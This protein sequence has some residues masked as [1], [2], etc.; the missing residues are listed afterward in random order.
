MEILSKP[1][2]GKSQQISITEL[3]HTTPECRFCFFFNEVFLFFKS[4]IVFL[5]GSLDRLGMTGRGLGMTGKRAREDRRGLG[6]TG[7]AGE[8]ESDLDSLKGIDLVTDERKKM[9]RRESGRSAATK[10]AR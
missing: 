7:W 5:Y 1:Q 8:R 2:S 10:S 3:H 9:H 4:F 6:R